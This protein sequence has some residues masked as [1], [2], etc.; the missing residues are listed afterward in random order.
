M[1]FAETGWPEALITVSMMISGVI[2]VWIMKKDN[3][4]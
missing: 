4:I 1:L 3:S 2:I